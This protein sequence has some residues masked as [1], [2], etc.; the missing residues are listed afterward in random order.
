MAQTL[1]AQMRTQLH[2]P[3]INIFKNRN[4][5]SQRSVSR[6]SGAGC[7]GCAFVHP[8]FG[9]WV[10][11]I[12]ILRNQFL[13]LILGLR[14]QCQTASTATATLFNVHTYIYELIMDLFVSLRLS[15]LSQHKYSL[16]YITKSIIPL[17]RRKLARYVLSYVT[18][19]CIYSEKECKKIHKTKD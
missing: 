18:Y 6:G 12:W 7:A 5:S 13:S 2:H 16:T 8:T 14:T 4:Q 1:G 10:R 15:V 11:K 9:P 17:N 3:W 19:L